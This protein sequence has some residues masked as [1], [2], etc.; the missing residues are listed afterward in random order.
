MSIVNKPHLFDP[1]TNCPVGESFDDYRT[2]G[3]WTHRA[4]AVSPTLSPAGP[5]QIWKIF[6][7]TPPLPYVMHI[8]PAI[9]VTAEMTVE[10]WENPVNPTG[11]N[12]IYSAN[13]N[14]R[15]DRISQ[16][17]GWEGV[18]TDSDGILLQTARISGDQSLTEYPVDAHWILKASHGY[19]VKVIAHQLGYAT[20]FATWHE[21]KEIEPPFPH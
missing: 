9:S 20:L 8:T 11:G 14:R 21:W 15:Y 7:L 17:V 10:Y 16:T 19:L 18:T 6:L 13:M 1:V 2:H 5:G 12:L 4:T 3:G